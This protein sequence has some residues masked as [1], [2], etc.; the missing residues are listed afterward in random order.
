M[1]RLFGLKEAY[2]ECK[3]RLLSNSTL[4]HTPNHH[5]SGASSANTGIRKGY[6]WRITGKIIFFRVK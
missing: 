4:A 3:H 2:L 6:K 1:Y 5:G